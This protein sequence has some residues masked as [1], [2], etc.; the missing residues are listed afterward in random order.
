VIDHLF[1]QNEEWARRMVEADPDYF[2]RLVKQQAPRL[3]WIGCS[4]ARVP[5]NT[6]L[7]LDPGDVFVHRNVANLAIHTDLNYLSVLQFAVDVLG[8]EDIIV[9]GHYGCG[10]IRAAL[11]SNQL[12]VIDNWLRHIRDIRDQHADVLASAA[13]AEEVEDLLVEANVLTQVYNVARAPILQNAWSRGRRVT[14]HG[15]AYRLRDGILHDL[16]YRVGSVEEI[17]EPHRVVP[18]R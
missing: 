10:G 16:G 2:A 11:R 15:V 7:G 4:D 8:V 14:V 9:C 17:G 18:H 5:A 6:I 1:A 3:L 13:D 12:G